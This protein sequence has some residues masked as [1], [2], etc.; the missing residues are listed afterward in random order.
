MRAI[1]ILEVRL[2]EAKGLEDKDFL[3]GMDPYVLI[4]YRSQEHKSSVAREDGEN[5]V[6]NEEFSFRIEYPG[7]DDEYKLRLKIMDKDTFS[8]DDF[9]GEA[10]IYLK[11]LFELGFENGGSELHPSR[12]RVIQADNT[13]CG[14]L[15]VG[16]KFTPKAQGITDREDFGGWTQSGY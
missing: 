6:W 4:Q 9:V 16:L 8:A 13:Y 11:D 3:G 14:E 5:P 7:A 2:V 15:Q 1:G 12:Y 10:T